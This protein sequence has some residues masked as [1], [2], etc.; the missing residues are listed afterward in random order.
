MQSDRLPEERERTSGMSLIVRMRTYQLSLKDKSTG[1]RAPHGRVS[2]DPSPLEKA[3]RR[4]GW[5]AEIRAESTE[6]GRD[7]HATRLGGPHPIWR[8]A[9]PS[10]AGLGK[11]SPRGTG[12]GAGLSLHRDA[13][14]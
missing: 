14:I 2:P 4:V 10:P 5:G 13:R 12:S 1:A 9:P 8:G 3:A 6:V 7:G 11:G